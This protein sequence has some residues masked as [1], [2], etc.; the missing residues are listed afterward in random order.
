MLPLPTGAKHGIKELLTV[1]SFA[2]LSK[3]CR[4]GGTKRKIW[5]AKFKIKEV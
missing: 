3:L 5:I 1:L 2:E 4:P